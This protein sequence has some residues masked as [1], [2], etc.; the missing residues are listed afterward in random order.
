[1][2]TIRRETPQPIAAERNKLLESK[3]GVWTIGDE[4]A[5]ADRNLESFGIEKTAAAKYRAA[6]VEIRQLTEAMRNLTVLF[7]EITNYHLP[8]KHPDFDLVVEEIEAAEALVKE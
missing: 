4:L 7:R 1:M 8:E 2:G 3:V 6:L 5:D